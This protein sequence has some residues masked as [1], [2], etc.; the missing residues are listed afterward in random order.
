MAV[1]EGTQLS[2]SFLRFYGEASLKMQLIEHNKE[3]KMILLW[4]TIGFSPE[5][6]LKY[7][8]SSQ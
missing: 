1:Q 2:E 5:K 3:L 7:P 6:H 4:I 8:K